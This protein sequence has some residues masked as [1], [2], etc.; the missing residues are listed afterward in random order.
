MRSGRLD[1]GGS[2]EDGSATKDGVGFTA[3]GS[4]RSMGCS[5]KVYVWLSEIA[6]ELH[7]QGIDL[8]LTG[9]RGFDGGGG[10]PELK[11]M[12]PISPLA[13]PLAWILEGF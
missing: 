5:E 11:K 4:L 2:G 10:W 3:T 12:M 7:A 13:A 1:N 8:R 6:R 9:G